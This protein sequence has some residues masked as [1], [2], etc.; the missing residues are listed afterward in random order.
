MPKKKHRTTIMVLHPGIGSENIAFSKKYNAEINP[1]I[2]KKA[3]RSVT[4]RGIVSENPIRPSYM[5]LT[6]RP[7][8]HADRPATRR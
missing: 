5:D 6:M 7:A 2:E 8:D 1:N 4:A 3:P